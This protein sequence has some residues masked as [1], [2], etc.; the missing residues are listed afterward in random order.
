MGLEQSDMVSMVIDNSSYRE[1]PSQN[2]LFAELVSEF[3]MILKN[4]DNKGTASLD[5]IMVS[6]AQVENRDEYK[7]EFY[8]LVRMVAKRG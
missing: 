1:K 7:D 8:Q 6:Y 3:A 2:L 4:S 5:D